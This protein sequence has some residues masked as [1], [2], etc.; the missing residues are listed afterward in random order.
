MGRQRSLDVVNLGYAGS[1]RGEIVS[2]EQLA[3][4]TADVISV[5]HG[6]NCWSRT[7]HSEAMF[8]AG[9]EAF[10]DL[11]RQGHPRT[12]IVAIS[13]KPAATA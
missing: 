10:F 4:L 3:S 1:A 7:P 11:L 6:T 12:P 5:A 13:T 9:L 2:A 8:R